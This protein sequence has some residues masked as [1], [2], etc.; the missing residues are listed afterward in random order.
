MNLKEQFE[1]KYPDTRLRRNSQRGQ[2]TGLCPFHEDSNPSFSINFDKN[3]YICFTCGEKGRV[4]YLLNSV[5]FT[6]T[7]LSD[8]SGKDTNGNSPHPYIHKMYEYSSE[9]EYS[10]FEKRGVERDTLVDFGVRKITV[11]KINDWDSRFAYYLR[12]TY[13]VD[14]G[15]FWGVRKDGYYIGG[16][17]WFKGK[18]PKYTSIKGSTGLMS[19]S[20]QYL[21]IAKEDFA[22]VVEGLFDAMSVY[23]SGFPV[24]NIFNS[25]FA[26]E[27]IK[28]VPENIKTLVLMLDNP[29]IDKAG[30]KDMWR[31]RRKI[32]KLRPEI[33]VYKY[34]YPN[35]TCKD[36]ND[37]LTEGIGIYS[38]NIQGFKK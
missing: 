30:Q 34:Y 29:L 2:Y 23:Q 31:A 33:L 1:N 20:I 26:D 9:P 3:C 22:F 28:A 27:Q 19:S 25:R 18:K 21:P 13:D 7:T 10:L 15:H 14:S 11:D 17:M 5:H 8:R 36:A 16:Q 6:P 37:L 24:I 38:G 35:D 12:K 32:H 4:S